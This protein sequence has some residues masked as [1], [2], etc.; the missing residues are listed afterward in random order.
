MLTFTTPPLERD[1][2][3]TGPIELVLYVA[4]DAR[5]TDFTGKLVDVHPD[6]RAELLTDGI[7]RARYRDSMSEPSLLEPGTVYELP[8]SPSTRSST[9][10]SI[11]RTSCCRSST[12][13]DVRVL[14]PCFQARCGQR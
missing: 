3:V 12:A 8:S 10:A 9:I 2:E 14:T 1:T 13:R 4:S 7:V 5:D 6:G 11:P